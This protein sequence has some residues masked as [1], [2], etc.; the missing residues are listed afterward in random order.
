MLISDEMEAGSV[1]EPA[2]IVF[3]PAGG[4][5]YRPITISFPVP[6]P[7]PPIPPVDS[8]KEYI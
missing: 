1:P 2:A 7:G 6:S 5:G 4:G 8:A 3:V